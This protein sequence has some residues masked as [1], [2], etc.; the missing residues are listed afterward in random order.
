MIIKNSTTSTHSAEIEIDQDLEFVFFA[1]DLED[2]S[3]YLNRPE[4]T[5]E[6]YTEA[7]LIQAEAKRLLKRGMNLYVKI[8]KRVD[9]PN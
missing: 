8:S 3:L 7:L 2:I 4:L 9:L 1:N 5:K 6:E